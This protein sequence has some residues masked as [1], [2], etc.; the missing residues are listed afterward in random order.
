[1]LVILSKKNSELP[2]RPQITSAYLVLFFNWI[3]NDFEIS[4][5]GREGGGAECLNGDI[6]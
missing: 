2:C 1:M 6:G 5:H 3:Q 4:F